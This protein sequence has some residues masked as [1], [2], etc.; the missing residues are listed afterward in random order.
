VNG[1]AWYTFLRKNDKIQNL[2]VFRRFQAFLQVFESGHHQEQEKQNYK[3][4]YNSHNI[5]RKK[6]F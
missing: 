5:N 2:A 6:R 3:M 4:F 1:Q